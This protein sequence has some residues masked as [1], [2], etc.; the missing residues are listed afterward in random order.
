M[1]IFRFINL[2]ELLYDIIIIIS[3][4]LLERYFEGLFFSKINLT[5]MIVA[6]LLVS[7]FYPIYLGRL[8]KRFWDQTNTN[9]SSD[10]K[11]I[12]L[13]V[14]KIIFPL[15]FIM[16]TIIGTGLYLFLKEFGYLNIRNEYIE[17]LI[18]VTTILFTIT[19]FMG[20]TDFIV[21][22]VAFFFVIFLYL[23]GFGIYLLDV[24]LREYKLISTIIKLIFLFGFPI[25][26]ALLIFKL[27]EI[28]KNKIFFRKRIPE[29]FQKN[30]FDV[31]LAIFFSIIGMLWGKLYYGIVIDQIHT[32]LGRFFY[33]L[34]SG[35][36][37]LRIILFLTPPIRLL[38]LLL[39]ML[40]T[41]IFIIFNVYK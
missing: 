7:L 17:A 6:L 9:H 32:P 8:G 18:L 39:G 14:R 31:F 21:G 38:N 23:W 27:Q 19:G 35:V 5:N 12:I 25:V 30:N 20:G 2:D 16:G 1:K 40:S 15:Y 29:F 24:F 36:I 22:V 13:I 10:F 11:E 41:I 37:P 33:L 28:L 4:L 26:V 3:S 34:F